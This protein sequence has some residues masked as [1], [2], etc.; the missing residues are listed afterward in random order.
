LQLIKPDRSGT[1]S[2]KFNIKGVFMQGLFV[3][4]LSS[5][6]SSAALADQA[7][8]CPAYGRNLPVNNRQVLHW[9][10]TTENQFRERAHVEGR[11]VQIFPDRNDHEHFV[12][13]LGRNEEDVLEVIYNKDFGQL[14]TLR[15][16]MMV[17]AC[18]DYITSTSR[19]GPY[20]ASPAG[21]IIHWIHMNPKNRGHEPGFLMVEG[22]LYGDDASNAGPKRPPKSK[23]SRHDSFDDN[24]L[25][26]AN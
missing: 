21:A 13:A 23:R 19:S 6:L 24:M 17:E 26:V 20:P 8:P 22:R 25:R 18:G 7:P 9:K 14:P 10:R 16:G 1:R 3:L 12:I 5:A 15:E 2:P 4:F 11:I